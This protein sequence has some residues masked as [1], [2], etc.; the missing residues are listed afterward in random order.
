MAVKQRRPQ[1]S[2]VRQYDCETAEVL[3]RHG[4][5]LQV[6]FHQTLG[7][8]DGVAHDPGFLQVSDDGIERVSFL[9]ELSV[10]WLGCIWHLLPLVICVVIPAC[11]Q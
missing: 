1:I 8:F 4:D 9:G 5:G 2:V 3:N 7:D 10:W 6:R 11:G